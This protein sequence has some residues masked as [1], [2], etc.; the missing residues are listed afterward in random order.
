MNRITNAERQRIHSRAME[1]IRLERDGST[2]NRDLVIDQLMREFDISRQRARQHTAKAAMRTRYPLAA[3][4]P[5][6][7]P[8]VTLYAEPLTQTTVR[9]PN[10]MI[11]WLNQQPGGFSGTIRE[12]IETA[13]EGRMT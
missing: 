1:L 13:M 7:T 4:Q 11:A 9:L 10:H 3:E 2:A 8:T 12:L 5:A 6:R